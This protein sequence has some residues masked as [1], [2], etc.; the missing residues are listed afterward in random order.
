MHRK[1]A[2]F[3]LILVVFA[4]PAFGVDRITRQ[5]VNIDAIDSYGQTAL[6]HAAE[7]GDCKSV[8]ELL[9]A[10]ANVNARG[11]QGDTALMSA[12]SNSHPTEGLKIVDALID[13]GADINIRDIRGRTALIYAAWCESPQ[14]LEITNALIKAG[15]V[16]NIKDDESFSALMYACRAGNV[17]G[18]EVAKA[19]IA[20]G[21][22]VNTKND[23]NGQTALMM[24]CD[25]QSWDDDKISEVAD[26]LIKAG[27]YINV[28]DKNG[29]SAVMYAEFWEA[30]K[31]ISVLRRAGAL[32]KL[33]LTQSEAYW[34]YLKRD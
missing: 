15:A 14:A 27:A 34:R 17:A 33:T 26:V 13:A 21:A 22:Y 3:M 24:L 25:N 20:A 16:L 5:K 30:N 2:A 8:V 6:M 9:E 7:Y 23:G 11:R 28:K 1:L 12:I 10:G 18:S 29:W 32:D 4:L 31:T 19:L